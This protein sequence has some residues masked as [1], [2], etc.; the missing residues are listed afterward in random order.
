MFML[1]NS[2]K[3]SIIGSIYITIYPGQVRRYLKWGVVT[4]LW[5]HS[6]LLNE[7]IL[8]GVWIF[9]RLLSDGQKSVFSKLVSPHNFLSEMFAVY[10]NV[11]TQRL[12]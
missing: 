4:E 2:R 1:T 10:I 12:S 6:P 11:R 7:G 8:C 5:H 3:K 9:L